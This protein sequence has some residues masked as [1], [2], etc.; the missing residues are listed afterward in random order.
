MNAG[1]DYA[2]ISS[3]EELQ[4]VEIEIVLSFDEFQFLRE[5]L[6]KICNICKSVKPPRVHHCSKCNR[7]VV[8]MDHHCPWVGNCV[9]F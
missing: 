4:L 8:R 7:C 2:K 6:L 9:G 3:D 5:R 1:S